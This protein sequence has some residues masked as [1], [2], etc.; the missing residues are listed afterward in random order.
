MMSV[1]RYAILIGLFVSAQIQARETPFNS[2]DADLLLQSCR[3]VVEIYDRK[4][5]LDKY[6]TFHTSTAE[7]LRAGYCIGVLVQYGRQS[8]SCYSSRYNSSNWFELAKA[9]ASLSFGEKEVER[10]QVSTLLERV[11]CNG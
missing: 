10:I 2:D 9:I 3:E 8:K 5:R 4:D 1:I 6:A 11:Y 7:A